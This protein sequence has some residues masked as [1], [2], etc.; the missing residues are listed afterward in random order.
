MLFGLELFES[1]LGRTGDKPAEGNL[2]GLL[3]P[4]VARRGVRSPRQQSRGRQ[5]GRSAPRSKAGWLFATGRT[6]LSGAATAVTTKLAGGGASGNSGLPASTVTF[7]ET[8]HPQVQGSV[9]HDHDPRSEV[10][11]TRPL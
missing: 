3:N 2:R 6:V 4:P 1:G 9:N 11:I 8:D 7:P 5:R 10:P